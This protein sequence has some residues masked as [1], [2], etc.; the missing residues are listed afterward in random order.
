MS[1]LTNFSYVGVVRLVLIG[2]LEAVSQNWYANQRLLLISQ[3]YRWHQVSITIL[4]TSQYVWKDLHNFKNRSFDYDVAS[5]T[6]QKPV[7]LLFGWR[8]QWGH[9]TVFFFS[10]IPIML[11]RWIG[12]TWYLIIIFGWVLDNYHEACI[13]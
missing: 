6:I 9:C 5:W 4:Q 12:L 2:L 10:W 13:T 1:V 3:M 7:N 8:S 11:E